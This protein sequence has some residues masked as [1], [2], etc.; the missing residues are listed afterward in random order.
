MAHQ[1]GIRFGR[2]TKI[3]DFDKKCDLISRIALFCET[4]QVLAVFF[5][6]DLIILA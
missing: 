2:I 6:D 3:H 1:Q 4:C 5:A